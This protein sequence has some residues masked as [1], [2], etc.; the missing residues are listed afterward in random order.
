MDDPFAMR[1][2]Q[3]VTDLRPKFHDFLDRQRTL[4]RLAFDAFHYEVVGTEIV[5]CADMRVIQGRYGTRLALEACAEFLA[6]DLNGDGS[7]QAGIMGSVHFAHTA[8]ADGRQDLVRSQP[9]SRS[10]GHG[11][12]RLYRAGKG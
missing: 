9:G 7:I 10:L 12:E 1:C 11:V 4:Q 8:L 5:E 2:I 6:A 3:S